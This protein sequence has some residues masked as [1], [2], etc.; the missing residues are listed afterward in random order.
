MVKTLDKVSTTVGPVTFTP[1]CTNITADDVTPE[2][3]QDDIAAGAL[4]EANEEIEKWANNLKADAKTAAGYDGDA[5]DQ[6]C[7]DK[8]DADW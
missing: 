6:A 8:F 7:K 4:A 1:S 3:A 5:C 2:N